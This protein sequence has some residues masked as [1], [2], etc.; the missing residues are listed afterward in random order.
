MKKLFSLV[1]V[2]FVFLSCQ[3]EIKTSTPSFQAEKDNVFWRA[4]GAK[5]NYNSSG[6]IIHMQPI[7]TL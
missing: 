1:A 3:Q 4:K 2:L 6:S 5:V 7:P